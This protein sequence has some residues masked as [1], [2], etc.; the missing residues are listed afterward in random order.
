MALLGSRHDVHA[1]YAGMDIF[2]LPSHRE[3]F[4]RSVMEASAMGVPVVAT[5]I[6]GCREAVDHD[7]SGLLVPKKDPEELAAALIALVTDADRRRR[8]GAGAIELARDRFDT[9]HQIEA[10]LLAYGLE[11]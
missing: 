2:V 6:R 4:P 10:S 5:D 7:R 9:N 8:L 3:G 1:L 11:Q